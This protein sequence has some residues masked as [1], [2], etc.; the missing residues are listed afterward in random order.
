[1]ASVR[2][3]SDYPA[4]SSPRPLPVARWCWTLTRATPPSVRWP[5]RH[6]SFSHGLTVATLSYFILVSQVYREQERSEKSE[7]LAPTP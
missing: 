5:Q 6:R 4:R 1:M 7:N 3:T 2:S